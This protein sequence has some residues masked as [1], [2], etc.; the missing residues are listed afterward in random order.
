MLMAVCH[1]AASGWVEVE[2]LERLSDLREE[3]GNVLWAEAEV[4]KLTDEDVRTIAEEFD[5]HP[6]AVEDALELGQRPKLETYESH[7][8]AVLQQLSEVDGQL[9]A[10]QLSCFMGDRYVLTIHDGAYRVLE[11]AKKRW[12]DE[13]EELQSSAYLMHT[14]LDVLVDDYGA[15]ADRVE[16]QIEEL[17]ETVLEVPN[18]P[19]QRQLYSLKQK[20]ARLRRYGTPTARA[21]DYVVEGRGTDLFPAETAPLFRD[22]HDHVLRITDQIRN[23]DELSQA[24]LDLSRAAQA[25]ALNDVTKRLSG[26]AAIIAVPTAIAGIYGMNF[27]LVPRD[28]TLFGFWF[29]VGL[30][31]LCSGGL[32]VFFKRRGWI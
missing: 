6:L 9:E 17:E 7:L 1:S 29:A 25:Q 8:F 19:V 3:K 2:D 11:E 27:E 23:V 28:Q 16:D 32:Y 4:G 13:P 30:M 22:V 26:W 24:V 12:R 20:V 18:A 31:L 21:L 5:L 14:L 15:I 10:V